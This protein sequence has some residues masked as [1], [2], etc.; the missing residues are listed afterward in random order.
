[1]TG[2][3]VGCLA[4]RREADNAGAR[5]TRT[6]LLMHL[7]RHAHAA[8]QARGKVPA[9]QHGHPRAHVP[10]QVHEVGLVALMLAADALL[11]AADALPLGALTRSLSSS[12]SS[13]SSALSSSSSIAEMPVGV[14]VLWVGCEDR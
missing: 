4:A 14:C 12:S 7:L 9:F 13:P 2:R 11:L 3:T 5:A 1:M 10:L 6:A 8:S